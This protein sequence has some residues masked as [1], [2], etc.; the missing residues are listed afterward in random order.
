MPLMFI[1]LLILIAIGVVGYVALKRGWRFIAE[2]LAGPWTWAALAEEH[3]DLREAVEIRNKILAFIDGREHVKQLRE[4]LDEALDGLVELVK[5]REDIAARLQHLKGVNL[6]HAPKAQVTQHH[7]LA[8]KLRDREQ[9]N[10]VQVSRLVDDLRQI[11]LDLLGTLDGG[12]KKFAEAASKAQTQMKHLNESV[13]SELE[14][15][16]FLK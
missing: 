14:L 16:A 15:S 5:L 10:N 4:E 12:E 7:T 13:Q 2:A 3:A 11:H 1:R 8:E 9:G 6:E